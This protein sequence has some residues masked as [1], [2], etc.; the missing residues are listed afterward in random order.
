MTPFGA[1]TLLLGS[2]HPESAS[3]SKKILP[4]EGSS[5]PAMSRSSV[6]F[7]TA[8]AFTRSA[9]GAR[10]YNALSPN[11][12]PPVTPHSMGTERHSWAKHSGRS[13]DPE[14]PSRAVMPP[15]WICRSMP[16]A[17]VNLPPLRVLYSLRRPSTCTRANK[18]ITLGPSSPAGPP[19]VPYKYVCIY[20]IIVPPTLT[21]F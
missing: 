9:Y 4:A 2:S 15:R 20:Y 18:P 5:S 17:A 7:P 12:T 16:S 13:P 21:P 8:T 11:Q 19:P 14:G 6:V 10:H 1:H 3:P